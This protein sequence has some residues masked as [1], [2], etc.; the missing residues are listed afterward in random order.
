M[1]H[2]GTIRRAACHGVA[3]CDNLFG[4][5]FYHSPRSII[6]K[7]RYLQGQAVSPRSKTLSC[8]RLGH[9]NGLG[10]STASEKLD[11]LERDRVGIL[12]GHNHL[13]LSLFSPAAPAQLS[14]FDS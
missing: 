11:R 2:E 10:A 4:R 3:L 14:M 13:T 7:R 9:G 8:G 5:P 6:A 1:I 12:C